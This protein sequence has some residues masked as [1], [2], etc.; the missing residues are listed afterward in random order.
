M[1]NFRALQA[2]LSKSRSS[3]K[4][5]NFCQQN[6]NF[7]PPHGQILA[8]SLAQH[9]LAKLSSLAFPSNLLGW[10]QDYL[11]DRSL[12]VTLNMKVYSRKSSNAGVPQESI[13]GPLMFIVFIDDISLHLENISI[14]YA[15]DVTLMSFS[16]CFY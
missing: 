13:L 7:W 2:H 3:I 8:T 11:L 15:H 12:K 1:S 5:I 14:L 6:D 10:L 9:L 16:C 4:V